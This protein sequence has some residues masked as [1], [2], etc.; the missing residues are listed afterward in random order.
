[1]QPLST[2]DRLR[3]LNALLDE[4]LDMP[5]EQRDAWLA[6]LPVESQ[7][8]APELRMLRAHQRVDTGDVIPRGAHALLDAPASAAEAPG[9][10]IGPYVC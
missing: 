9:D 7:S 8:L 1:M 5:A 6:G 10:V 4:A 3:K 2:V